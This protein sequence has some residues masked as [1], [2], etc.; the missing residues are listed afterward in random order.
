MSEVKQRLLPLPSW[1]GLRLPF[2]LCFLRPASLAVLG[3]SRAP[4]LALGNRRRFHRLGLDRRY[5]LALGSSTS[6][7][8]DISALS[9][10]AVVASVR[11]HRHRPH[12][13]AP[14]PRARTPASTATCQVC[15][16]KMHVNTV[17]EDA[18]L[19]HLSY[20]DLQH[21]RPK[22]IMRVRL[23]ND[24]RLLLIKELSWAGPCSRRLQAPA[25]HP[26]RL[27]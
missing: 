2:V 13:Q 11:A 24:L 1:L 27:S 21:R 4:L 12:P 6:M 26:H 3:L 16:L 18:D 5:G 15:R 14:A 23:V 9:G 19:K 8:I 25:R 10:T 17:L 7:A 20:S 22:S